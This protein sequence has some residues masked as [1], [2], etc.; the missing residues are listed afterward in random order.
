MN[1]NRL[2]ERP[3]IVDHGSLRE[4]TASL[5]EGGPQDGLVFSQGPP[6]VLGHS[7]ATGAAAHDACNGNGGKS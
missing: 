4:L 5:R 1:E 6:P 2:Y 3:A 7:C